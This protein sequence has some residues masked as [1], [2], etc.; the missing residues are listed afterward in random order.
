MKPTLVALLQPVDYKDGDT[1]LKIKYSDGTVEDANE[2][3]F[4]RQWEVWMIVEDTELTNDG[5]YIIF[6]YKTDKP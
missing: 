3:Y 2:H 4:H 6:S 1:G 5:E